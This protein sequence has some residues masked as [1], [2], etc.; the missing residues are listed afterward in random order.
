MQ[1]LGKQSQQ[2]SFSACSEKVCPMGQSQIIRVTNPALVNNYDVC[3]NQVRFPDN[4]GTK[5]LAIVLVV[6]CTIAILLTSFMF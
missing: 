5:T 3:R 6:S 4:L 2:D 1:V